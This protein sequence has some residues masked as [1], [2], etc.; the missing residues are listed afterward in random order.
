MSKL[1][2]PRYGSLQFWPRVRAEKFLPS[3][4]WSVV[5]GDSLKGFIA[6][7]AGMA[8]AI[9]KDG[10]PKSMTPGKKLAV[11]VTVLEV[12]P[13]KIYSVR[14]YKKG[15]VSQEFVVSNDRDLKRVVRVA[16]SPVNV[17]LLDS[18]KDFD[19]IRA[20]VYSIP[21]HIGIKKTPDL[22]EVAVGGKDKLAVVKNLIGKELNLSD[23][24]KGDLVD[25]RGLTKGK[26]LSGP[27]E[28]FGISLKAHKS[29]KGRRKPGSLGP[30]H[31]A[32]VI[33][34]VPLSGQLGM[35]TRV[36][37][38]LKVLSSGMSGEKIFSKPFKQYGFVKGQYL[39][40]HGS[41]QGPAMRQ[42]LVTQPIRPTLKQIRK[43]Y[44]LIEVHCR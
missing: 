42:I 36:H 28:R 13:M 40:V 8:T 20:I 41:V 3:V 21:R 19:E 26:G 15:I 29:E 17:S 7:K 5:S 6:Y 11:P 37:Y 25:V 2:R 1:S 9:V 23:F 31:P 44:D 24:W 10:T 32:R 27:V 34:R 14:F 18:V 38:N 43:K 22:A 30:W 4:N 33:F 39:L 12:P 35:F 16:K